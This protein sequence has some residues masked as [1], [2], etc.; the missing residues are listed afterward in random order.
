MKYAPLHP[1]L[2]LLISSI[3]NLL[4]PPH[5][6]H[7]HPALHT[8]TCTHTASFCV[9]MKLHQTRPGSPSL[10]AY[11]GRSVTLRHFIA[12][13][14]FARSDVNVGFCRLCECVCVSSVVG[15]VTSGSHIYANWC[16]PPPPHPP[17]LPSS[18]P[19]H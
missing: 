5:T 10:E 18:S 1:P 3:H 2:F 11:V 15:K 7:T 19:T 13:Q 14:W 12:L 9:A 16:A 6:Q 17:P 4:N 8:H